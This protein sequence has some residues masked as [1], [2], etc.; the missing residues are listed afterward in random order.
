[1]VD[2]SYIAN[3]LKS[4]CTIINEGQ[5]EEISY[6]FPLFSMKKIWQKKPRVYTLGYLND[7]EL[8]KSSKYRSL[9]L[10]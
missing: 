1:M 2:N 7:L 10:Y 9:L 6:F 8:R 3:I 4:I 5:N